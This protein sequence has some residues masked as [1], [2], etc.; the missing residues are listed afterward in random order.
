MKY[1]ALARKYRP[2]NFDEIVSQ[3]FVVKTL[4]N[5]IELGR[6]SHSYIFTG[7][8]G[9]GKTSAARIFAK[10][11]NCTDPQGVNPCNKCDNCME[12]TE[13][14][15]ID[16]IEI[17]GA[18]NRGI[19]E[20]REL[21]ETVKFAPSKCNYKVYIIDEVHMLTDQAFNALLKTLEEPP[22]HVLFIMATTEA[23]K[24]PVT[25]LSRSQKY[26]FNKIPFNKMKEFLKDI[27]NKENIEFE[28][29]ALNIIVRNSDGCMRDALS[30]IDQI[31]AFT[32]GKITL[33]DTNF[34]LGNADKDVVEKLL[35]I[36]FTENEAELI[37]IIEEISLKGLG[38]KYIIESLISHIRNLLFGITSKKFDSSVFTEEEISF[39]EKLMQ[40]ANKNK[41]FALF[42]ILQSTLNDIKYFD[43]E[44]YVF[45]MGMFKCVNISKIINVENLNTNK[46][47]T[48]S[49]NFKKTDEIKSEPEKFDENEITWQ[50]FLKKISKIKPSL[51]SN[52]EHGYVS[53]LTDKELIIGFSEEKKWHYDFINKN[54]N[55]DI[56]QSEVKTFFNN[57][58]TVKLVIENGSKKKTVIEKKNNIENFLTRKTKK[59]AMEN[60]II[61][62]II[63]EFNGEVANFEVFIN[64]KNQEE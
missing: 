17:D 32:E 11:V 31:S 43:F 5:A 53:T 54:D 40:H 28:N 60:P 39:Y 13:G 29:D 24:I 9:V 20:I 16:V 58:L 56:L 1:I 3:D 26:N 22:S 42:Q 34:L 38:Y 61:K 47:E 49:D 23:N 4:K 36:I 14:T 10:A 30:L 2:Q 57:D 59:E 37:D 25:I 8:R 7:P 41:C 64:I 27:L 45:E 18:S 55:I 51:S 44:R 50:K 15:S 21:R 6:V 19:D 62:K 12:I 52:L 46:S 63:E 33:N 48:I 35:E